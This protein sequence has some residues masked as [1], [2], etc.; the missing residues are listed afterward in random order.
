MVGEKLSSRMA[1]LTV[2]TVDGATRGQSLTTRETVEVD[3]PASCA[4]FRK[5]LWV[6][7]QGRHQ[8]RWPESCQCLRNIA[9]GKTHPAALKPGK[10][11]RTTFVANR[12]PCATASRIWCGARPAG[13]QQD[14]CRANFCSAISTLSTIC[15]RRSDAP[16]W[17]TEHFPI[18]FWPRTARPGVVVVGTPSARSDGQGV[19]R[20]RPYWWKSAR[21][22][23]MGLH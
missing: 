4:T 9:S 8:M 23:R 3:T 2:S 21:L 20:A 12:S 10:R 17:H 7:R 1:R 11:P 15:S 6:L 5:D 22:G 19:A 14:Q 13:D 16:A 18:S